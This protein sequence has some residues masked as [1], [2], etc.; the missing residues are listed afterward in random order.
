MSRVA[1]H[2][3]TALEEDLPS[4]WSLAT[5]EDLVGADGVFVDGDWVESK[6]QD[7]TGD[8]RLI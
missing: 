1:E 2:I 4:A 6:D 8:V 5:I 3:H 7:P